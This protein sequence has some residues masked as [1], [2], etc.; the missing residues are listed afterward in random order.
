MEIEKVV[1]VMHY[2]NCSYLINTHRYYDYSKRSIIDCV[3]E[4]IA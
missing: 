2:L 1:S 4:M 3:K